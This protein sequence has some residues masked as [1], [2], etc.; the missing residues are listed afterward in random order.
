MKVCL[1]DNNPL[2]MLENVRH[3]IDFLCDSLCGAREVPFTDNSLNGA[4][5]IFFAVLNDLKEIQ[6]RIANS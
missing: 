1:E 4:Q 5:L 2:N 6:E 3:M